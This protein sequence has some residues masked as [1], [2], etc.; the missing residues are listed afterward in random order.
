M[1]SSTPQKTITKR[2]DIRPDIIPQINQMVALYEQKWGEKPRAL[3]LGPI[4]Y[5]SLVY[6]EM[7]A[8]EVPDGKY[9][10]PVVELFN[11]IPVIPRCQPGI[12]MS[13]GYHMIGMLAIGKIEEN[14]T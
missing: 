6:A 14:L 12:D 3:L 13:P 7:M 10:E 2:V 1:N 11:E 9:V 8:K 5:L 4:E